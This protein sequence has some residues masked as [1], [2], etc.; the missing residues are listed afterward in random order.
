MIL[1]ITANNAFEVL[2]EDSGQG[3]AKRSDRV[4]FRH[5]IRLDRTGSPVHLWCD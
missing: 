4:I 1:F 5:P 3:V 2:F